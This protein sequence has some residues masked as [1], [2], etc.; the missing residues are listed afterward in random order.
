[1]MFIK[2]HKS[3]RKLAGKSWAANCLTLDERFSIVCFSISCFSLLFFG[4]PLLG[5]LLGGKF[6]G[7]YCYRLA[8]APL[9]LN[10]A[11]VYCWILFVT[12]LKLASSN[13]ND[14]SGSGHSRREVLW[15]LETPAELT[16]AHGYLFWLQLVLLA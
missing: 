9:S 1:M 7:E 14:S 4:A 5:E 3:T 13:R 15:R 6:S 16:R 12:Y 2:H 10:L 11:G 8:D